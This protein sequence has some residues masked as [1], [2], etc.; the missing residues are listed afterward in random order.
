MFKKSVLI[1]FLSFVS[2]YVNAQEGW[3]KQ[4]INE[5]VTVNF[6]I[7]CKKI[8]DNSYG[9]KNQDDVVFLISSVDLLKI[10]NLSLEEFNKNVVLQSW[11]NEFMD[12]L[13]P[14]MPKFTFKAAE[15]ITLKGQTA[16]HVIGRDEAGKSTIFMNIVFVDGTAHS[17]TSLVPDGKS[18]KNTDIFLTNI[19]VNK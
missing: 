5:K 12:G 9:I 13:T 18:T 7:E 14:T 3:F 6:P 17:L 19:S 16:Y 1:L 10:T 4:K 2:I 15:I 11:A 8:N